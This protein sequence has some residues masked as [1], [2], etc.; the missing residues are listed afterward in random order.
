MRECLSDVEVIDEIN[1]FSEKS[2]M[3]SFELR[4]L[5]FYMKQKEGVQGLILTINDHFHFLL[6]PG[7]IIEAG[8]QLMSCW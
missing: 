7:S 2:R 3:T 6:L 5:E 4:R 8:I 1:Q